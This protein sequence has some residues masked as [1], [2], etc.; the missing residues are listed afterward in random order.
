MAASLRRIL[1]ADSVGLIFSGHYELEYLSI[2]RHIQRAP[3]PHGALGAIRRVETHGAANPLLRVLS[4]SGRTDHGRPAFVGKSAGL[5]L[6]QGTEHRRT[7]A[8]VR[9]PALR[10]PTVDEQPAFPTL[11]TAPWNAAPVLHAVANPDVA[12]GWD[13]S[14]II[15]ASGHACEAGVRTDL[16]TDAVQARL[17]RWTIRIRS[18]WAIRLRITVRFHT[19]TSTHLT[20]GAQARAKTQCRVA[21]RRLS[22]ALVP[23]PVVRLERCLGGTL[24]RSSLLVATSRTHLAHHNHEK[25]CQS[26]HGNLLVAVLPT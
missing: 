24:G 5:S 19:T 18:A 6:A 15:A 12:H 8:P 17:V 16:G 3:G 4:R 23:G 11:R 7:T 22:G 13:P 10:H 25:P 9:C 14:R 1:H 21:G 26:S 20:G 2:G